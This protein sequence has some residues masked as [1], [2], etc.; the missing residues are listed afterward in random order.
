MNRLLDRIQ[1]YLGGSLGISY[2]LIDFW[3]ESI[4]NWIALKLYAVVI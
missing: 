3:E 1:I 4:K 2:D